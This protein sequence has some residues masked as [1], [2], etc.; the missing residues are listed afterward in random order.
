MMIA[1]RS[2]EHPAAAH[3]ASIAIDRIMAMGDDDHDRCHY[4][5]QDKCSGILPD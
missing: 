1:K 5:W 3:S 2:N 4:H